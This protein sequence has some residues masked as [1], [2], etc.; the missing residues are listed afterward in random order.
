[1]PLAIA[2]PKCKK[3]Y[4]LPD[5]F[6]GKPVKCTEC[7]TQ[8]KTPAGRPKANAQAAADPKQ[9]EAK[10]RAQAEAVRKANELK[11]LGVE[12]VIRR[13]RDIFDGLNP[14]HG[15]ADPLNNHVIEDPG[16]E[17][18]A[19]APRETA[20]INSEDDPM[21]GMFENPALAQ[22]K[23]KRPKAKG[24]KQSGGFASQAWILAAAIFSFIIILIT[25]LGATEVI[26]QETVQRLGNLLGIPM[27][28]VALAAHIW[29]VVQTYK[30]TE[31]G[32]HTALTAI[33]PFYFLYPTITHWD[34]MKHPAL[35]LIVMI[36][37]IPV[38]LLVALAIGLVVGLLSSFSQ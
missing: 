2:C 23:K 36:L 20:D 24:R 7:K 13:E 1:M 14:V 27:F 11:Q 35:L 29:V 34:T 28:F 19:M 12:G 9:L 17:A 37:I 25:L 26:S 4:N 16:F 30:S 33:I 22:T 3:K 38:L 15:T 10:K 32:L 5:K 8:F 6:R 18:A 31:S 21:A